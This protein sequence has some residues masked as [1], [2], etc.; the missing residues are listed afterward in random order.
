MANALIAAH[1]HPHEIVIELAR[2][3]KLSQEKKAEVEKA[4]EV[5]RAA[6]EA[7]VKIYLEDNDAKQVGRVIAAW[8]SEQDMGAEDALAKQIDTYLS[9][10][11]V[12]SAA[13]ETLVGVLEA[14]ETGED[15]GERPK[16]I[17]QVK[18]WRQRL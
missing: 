1:G 3:L 5:L 8:L 7:L 9:L 14:I 15:V 4:G 6:R 10:E 17:E 18:V 11:E 16:W 13:K 2:D 12:D